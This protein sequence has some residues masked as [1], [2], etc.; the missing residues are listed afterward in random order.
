MGAL[1]AERGLRDA[2]KAR[3]CEIGVRVRGGWHS[4]ARDLRIK[5][6]TGL[7]GIIILRETSRLEY[8]TMDSAFIALLVLQVWSQGNKQF[9]LPVHV[10]SI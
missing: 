1:C 2:G 6:K 3:V 9:A 4:I 5:Y 10:R 7:A 8:N